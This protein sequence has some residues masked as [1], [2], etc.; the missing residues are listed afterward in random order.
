[1]GV[2]AGAGKPPSNCE[3]LT[4]ATGNLR[5]KTTPVHSKKGKQK[6]API[7]PTKLITAQGKSEAPYFYTYIY[8]CL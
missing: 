8:I 1:M 2:R 7:A 4:L 5:V 3:L 6:V